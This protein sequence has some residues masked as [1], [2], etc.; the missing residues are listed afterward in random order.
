MRVNPP[1]VR[2]GNPAPHTSKPSNKFLALNPEQRPPH[3]PPPQPKA[4]VCVHKP[5]Q[6]SPVEHRPYA[7]PPERDSKNSKS[8]SMIGKAIQSLLGWVK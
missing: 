3:I 4:P 7:Q 8:H 2:F 6:L 1:Q 5:L